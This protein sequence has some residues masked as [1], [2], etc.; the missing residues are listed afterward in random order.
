MKEALVVFG[1]LAA[2]VFVGGEFI[3]SNRDVGTGTRNDIIA[4]ASQLKN[5]QTKASF[6]SP[7]ENGISENDARTLRS[8]CNETLSNENLAIQLESTKVG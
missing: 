3:N 2:I 4:C 5:A 1:G 7:L 8:S 6:L